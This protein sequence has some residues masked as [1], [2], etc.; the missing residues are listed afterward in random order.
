MPVLDQGWHDNLG[1]LMSEVLLAV[2]T[3]AGEASRLADDNDSFI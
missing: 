2:A 3:R 1:L